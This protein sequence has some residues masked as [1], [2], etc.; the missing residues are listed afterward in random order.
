M[1]KRR[2]A[3]F[4]MAALLASGAAT[5]H[6]EDA[7]IELKKKRAAANAAESGGDAANAVQRG[8]SL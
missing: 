2:F 7:S 1:K 8:S 5:T 4:A 3:V 6:G